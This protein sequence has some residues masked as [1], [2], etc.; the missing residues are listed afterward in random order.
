MKQITMFGFALFMLLG[1]VSCN[2]QGNKN[3]SSQK[4]ISS[5]VKVYY[6][7]FTR[8]CNTCM[9][10]EATAK[11]AFEALYADKV[12]TGE[13]T[14]KAINLD[15]ASSKAIAEKLGVGGQTLLVVYGN[16]KVDI[17]DKGFM[18]AHDFVK[19]KEEIKKAVEQVTKG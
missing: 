15:D 12:K 5:K 10:V 3:E 18:N 16:Q 13:C 7:H 2:A 19:M 17:T 6:F 4:A 9:S 1:G 14:F 8:R 11:Q